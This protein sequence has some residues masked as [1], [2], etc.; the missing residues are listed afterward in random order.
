[1]RKP[2]PLRSHGDLHLHLHLRKDHGQRARHRREVAAGEVRG[3][4]ER[5][6]LD[7][8]RSRGKMTRSPKPLAPTS[9]PLAG[10]LSRDRGPIAT[11]A[12]RPAP[13]SR[14][15]PPRPDSPGDFS[16]EARRWIVG[17]K[18]T[19]SC[20]GNSSA[21]VVVAGGRGVPIVGERPE[22]P[23]PHLCATAKP[24]PR[25]TGRPT[26]GEVR[27]ITAHVGSELAVEFGKRREEQ[28]L[29]IRQAIEEA[30][31]LWVRSD[32]AIRESR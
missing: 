5:R 13:T 3:H 18:V 16:P 11:P 1:M 6:Q 2:R 15:R 28:R 26:R 21:G 25:P 24:I 19:C 7:G 9:A 22:D 29:T 30:I 23:H 14:R 31:R 20:L 10:S 12:K 4:M 32:R 8:D 17:Q 27:V